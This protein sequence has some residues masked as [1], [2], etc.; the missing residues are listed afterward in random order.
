MKNTSKIILFILFIF[1]ISTAF[2]QTIECEILEFSFN[3]N[4]EQEEEDGLKVKAIIKVN[5]IR[6][7]TIVLKTNVEL[8]VLGPR[9]IK[10]Y[11]LD[12]DKSLHPLVSWIDNEQNTE[13]SRNFQLIKILVPDKRKATIQISY[14]VVGLSSLRYC[15]GNDNEDFYTCQQRHEYY[16]PM[17]MPIREVKVSLPDSVKH[18]VSYKKEGKIIRDINLSFINKNN[19][20]EKVINKGGL[21]VSLH[22]PDTLINNKR[23]QQNI[24]DMEQYL[25][26]LSTYLSSSPKVD[27]IYINWRDDKTRS[28]FGEALGNHAVCDIHFNNKD[29]LHEALHMLLSTNIEESSKGEYFMKE[30]IIEWL[31]L[32]LSK[33]AIN[34]N[35]SDSTTS[36]SLYDAQIN[37]HTTWNLIYITGPT[38]IQR[39]ASKCG[40]EKMASVIFSFLHKNKNKEINYDMFITHVKKYLSNDLA[41]EL[42]SLV[43]TS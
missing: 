1:N 30:S 8:S 7:D 22:I 43:T 27:I 34:T 16:Y 29:L 24:V 28:A 25:G 2:T 12:R 40:E 13:Q 26:R 39:I 33:K 36:V 3:P 32:F 31:A 4:A 20:R 18:F 35:L 14:N 9:N 15:T 10:A 38:I 23:M 21:N 6:N 5:D 17:N 42:N 11:C 37:N 19:Y 41:N